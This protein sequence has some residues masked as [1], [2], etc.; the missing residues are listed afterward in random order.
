MTDDL[1]ASLQQRHWAAVN[2]LRVVQYHKPGVVHIDY[3]VPHFR[4]P[5]VNNLRKFG[6]FFVGNP[7]RIPYRG[8]TR[9]FTLT[10]EEL[11][12]IRRKLAAYTSSAITTLIADQSC[13]FRQSS[14]RAGDYY[15]ASLTYE[16]PVERLLALS[17]ALEAL[18]SPGDS[19]EYSFRI[20]QT[21]SQLLGKSAPERK[22]IYQELRSL[23]DKRSQLMHGTY[24][25][26]EVY[27]GTFVT[28]DEIDSWSD[29]IRDALLRFLILYF[30]GKRTRG[31]LNTVR[32]DLLLSA[33]DS[34]VAEELRRLSDLEVF[35]G[36][37]ERGEIT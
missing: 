19:H 30:R 25:V 21:A 2:L 1:F 8:G 36:E 13:L 34:G 26:K 28:H 9:F 12:S 14:L 15:E 27:D 5:W 10:E 3:S 4:P 7:R 35:L 33:L 24:K 29:H 16:Q 23:Y 22:R 6:L 18:F 31:D 17:V 37:L 11:P 20:S 32:E